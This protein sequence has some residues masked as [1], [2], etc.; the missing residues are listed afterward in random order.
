VRA[1]VPNARVVRISPRSGRPELDS[2]AAS[3]AGAD[4]ILVTTHV[5]TIEGAGRFA[6]APAVAQWIDSLATREKVIVVAH[7]N[8][9][10]IRQFPRVGSYLVTYGVGDALE[11]AA[12]RAAL[13]L[14]PIT[15]HAPISL[16]GFF[17]RGDGLT[18]S[19]PN[20]TDSTR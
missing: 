16:P 13:G 7:G 5:R 10:V 20:A 14:A 19:A 1:S 6:V 8:P 4:A 11:R 3:L 12:A 9:Y 15:A 17:A 2:L 18:R